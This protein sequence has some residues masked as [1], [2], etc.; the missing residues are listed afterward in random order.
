MSKNPTVLVDLGAGLSLISGLPT[1]ASW[2][3][4]GR[5][6]GA[7]RGT[8]G[9]NSQTKKLEYWDG[10]SWFAALMEEN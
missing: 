1:I 2:N 5:P 7:K 9:F 4:D 10:T 6:K 8:F 3:T